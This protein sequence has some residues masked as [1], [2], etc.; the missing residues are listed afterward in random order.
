MRL[1]H[2]PPKQPLL[3]MYPTPWRPPPSLRGHP[4]VHRHP[5][6]MICN[7]RPLCCHRVLLPLK[8]LLCG[9][10]VAAALPTTSTYRCCNPMQLLLLLPI[11]PCTYSCNPMHASC[12]C[13]P[14]T[15]RML[16]GWPLLAGAGA[17]QP[18]RRLLVRAPRTP[19]AAG[20]RAAIPP[21]AAAGA[22]RTHP[23]GG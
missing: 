3:N 11:S 4:R 6:M 7:I 17:C 1:I 19:L 8:D 23:A 20:A 10:A 2:S 14:C 9:R 13:C 5:V 18:R 15:C 22:P 21:L 12:C 16:A